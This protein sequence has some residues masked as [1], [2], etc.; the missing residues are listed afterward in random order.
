MAGRTKA[1]AKPKKPRGKRG[2]PASLAAW[3]PES[4]LLRV[5]VDTPRG[6]AVKYKLDAEKGVYK[7]AH[8]LPSGMVFPFDFGSIPGTLADDGDPLDLLVVAEAGTFPGCL[9]E[10]RLIGGLQ[11][12]QTQRGKTMRNDRLV[13]VGAESRAYARTRRLSDLPAKLLDEVERFF[14]TY[15]EARGRRFRVDRRV[16]PGPARRLVREGERRFEKKG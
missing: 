9:V 8:I 12:R 5:L 3:D 1:K 10:V 6:S 14:V 11:A 16:G 2:S 4:G 7:V 13:G 15:N